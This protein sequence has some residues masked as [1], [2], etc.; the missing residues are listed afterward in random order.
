MTVESDIRARAQHHADALKTKID[1][2]VA[3]MANDDTSHYLIY[4]VLGV[5][6]K[7]GHLIDVYQNKGRFLYRYAGSFLEDAA[8]LCFLHKFPNTRTGER[9]PNTIGQRP[10]TFEIDCLLPNDDALEVKWRD[11]TTD[12]D[13]IQKEHTRMRNIKDAGYKPIRVM[14]YYPNREQA[15]RIQRTIEDLYRGVGGEYHYGDDAW[16]FVEKYTD[17]DLKGILERIAEENTVDG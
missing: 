12:G 7:E 10:K 17:V 4:R 3:E 6:T 15:Q 8:K 5:A 9:I 11:A 1:E 14:F 16:N 2:R 13:H